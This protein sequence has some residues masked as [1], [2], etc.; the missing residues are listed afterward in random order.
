MREERILVVDDDIALCE[1]VR[2]A[3][4]LEGI[5]V[6]EAHHACTW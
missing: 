3:L 6:D 1:L 2:A 5:E 4:E